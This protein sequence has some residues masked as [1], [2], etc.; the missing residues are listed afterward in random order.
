MGA[1]IQIIW[2]SLFGACQN[3][4]QFSFDGNGFHLS[5]PVLNIT[6]PLRTAVSLL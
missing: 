6:L 1:K 2:V 3:L 4:F 5:C